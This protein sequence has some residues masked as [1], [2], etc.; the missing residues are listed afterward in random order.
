MIQQYFCPDCRYSGA[1]EIPEHAGVFEVFYKLEDDHRS[2]SPKCETGYR[3]LRVRNDEMC[4]NEEW[5][6]LVNQAA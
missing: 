6:A 3:S 5:A 1:V 4:S 2:N